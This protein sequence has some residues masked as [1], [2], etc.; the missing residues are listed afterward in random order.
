MDT[1]IS[2]QAYSFLFSVASGAIIGLFYDIL[3]IKRRTIKTGKIIVNIEDFFYWILVAFV[4]FGMVYYSYEEELRGYIF[5]GTIIG[6]IIYALVLS[7]FVIKIS[8]VIIKMINSFIKILFKIIMYPINILYKIFTFPCKIIL[9]WIKKP[10]KLIWEKCKLKIKKPLFPN[11]GL[12]KI[13]KKANIHNLF[14]SGGKTHGQ[15]QK[16]KI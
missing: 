7:N 8:L 2:N 6:V 14:H 16:K 5:L 11:G 1:F 4:M 3:R 9:K 10:L 12:K 13:R 15:K